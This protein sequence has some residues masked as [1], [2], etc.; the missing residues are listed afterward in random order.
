MACWCAVTRAEWAMDGKEIRSSFV[1]EAKAVRR[2]SGRVKSPWQMV[3]PAKVEYWCGR[4]AGDRIER[5]RL[6]AGM[7][8]VERRW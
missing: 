4:R 1:T 2:V 8:R 6:E 7:W 3:M 5:I